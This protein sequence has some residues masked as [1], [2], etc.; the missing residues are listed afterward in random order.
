MAGPPKCPLARNRRL[1]M[2]HCPT[3]TQLKLNLTTE[4]NGPETLSEQLTITQMKFSWMDTP[5][6]CS[7]CR[8]WRC[9][10]ACALLQAM[11]VSHSSRSVS[12]C[13][14]VCVFVCTHVPACVCGSPLVTTWPVNSSDWYWPTLNFSHVCLRSERWHGWV[15]DRRLG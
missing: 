11:R 3:I 6:S 9:V 7:E 15:G 8:Y 5:F 4:A 14:S 13:V 2:A 10:C 12:V 1:L